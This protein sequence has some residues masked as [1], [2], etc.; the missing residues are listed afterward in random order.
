MSVLEWL[1]AFYTKN[2]AEISFPLVSFYVS[3]KMSITR[4]IRSSNKRV[5]K[6]GRGGVVWVIN[7]NPYRAPKT[8]LDI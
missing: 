4:S 6:L 5:S 1:L 3:K 2:L 7:L 8:N